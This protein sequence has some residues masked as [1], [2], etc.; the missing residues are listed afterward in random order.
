MVLCPP[1]T[2]TERWVVMA[3]Q[4]RIS[5]GS[6]QFL[7]IPAGMLDE[8]TGDFERGD[9]TQDPW[10]GVGRSDSTRIEGFESQR[11]AGKMPCI[12]VL[13]GQTN[14]YLFIWGRRLAC[15]NGPTKDSSADNIKGSRS[16]KNRISPGTTSWA[17][18]A[19]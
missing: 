15:F 12:Q 5:V 18:D 3:E 4:P 6:L 10:R 16:T 14:S 19:R 1:N 11:F 9:G 7:E 17:A 13:A 2:R 8:E